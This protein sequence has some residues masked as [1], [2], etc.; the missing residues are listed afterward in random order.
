MIPSHDI[1]LESTHTELILHEGANHQ[2]STYL[3]NAGKPQL[4]ACSHQR[5]AHYAKCHLDRPRSMADQIYAN[6]EPRKLW[7]HVRPTPQDLIK[8][9]K[10]GYRRRVIEG[11]GLVQSG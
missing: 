3:V 8:A 4:G 5:Q 1:L 2:N 9:S 10:M 6:I 7:E 11:G